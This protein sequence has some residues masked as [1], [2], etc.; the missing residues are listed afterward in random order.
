MLDGPTVGVP[1]LTGSLLCVPIHRMIRTRGSSS[2]PLSHLIRLV[3]I[4]F[5]SLARFYVSSSFQL[6]YSLVL[7]RIQFYFSEMVS[8]SKKRDE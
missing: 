3:L 5:I 1:F 8:S 6:S 4:R 2:Q 7:L